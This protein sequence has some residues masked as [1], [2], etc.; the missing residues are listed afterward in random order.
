MNYTSL[1]QR[2]DKALEKKKK[3]ENIPRRL[4]SQKTEIPED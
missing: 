3:S 1:E 4:K 2:L